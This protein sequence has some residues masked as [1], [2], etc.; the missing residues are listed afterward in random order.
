MK[1]TS[2]TQLVFF[3][4]SDFALPAL[5]ALVK[6]GYDIQAVITAPDQASGRKQTPTPPPVKIA[7]EKLGLKIIQPTVLKDPEFIAYCL[8]L[9]ADLG[10]VAAYGKI[11]PQAVID[12]FPLGTINLHP[13]L[14]PKYRGPSPIQYA[15]LNGDEETGVTIIKIDD[16]VDHGPI[17]ARKKLEKRINEM[18][19]EKLSRELSRLSADL[20]LKTLLKY[21]NGKIKPTPQN[22]AYA[23]FTKM[24]VKKD[25]KI[26][27]NQPAREI[28][29]Q[30]RA[31]HYWPGIWTTWR[32]K[33]LKIID[34]RITGGKIEILRLQLDGRKETT[35]K[36]FISGYGKI[37]ENELE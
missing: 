31:F 33:I 26:D 30:F 32:G 34:C 9:K 24:I 27:W 1:K 23:T 13:S 3:G 11:I 6:A 20:L 21:L 2:K 17:V 28:Y 29:D 22:E 10:V 7:A 18:K 4:S 19:Y 37:M 15:L 16:Q 5:E 36:N 35:M 25:G 8:R 14:L 12:I